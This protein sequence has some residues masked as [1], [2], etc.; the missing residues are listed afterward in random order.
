MLRQEIY[1]E[2][3]DEYDGQKKKLYINLNMFVSTQ[4]RRLQLWLRAVETV[5]KI[6]LHIR[7]LIAAAICSFVGAFL[8]QIEN[9]GRGSGLDG[10]QTLRSL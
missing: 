3:E 5:L 1:I 10:L 8:V 6:V 2:D 4:R 9:G 7:G